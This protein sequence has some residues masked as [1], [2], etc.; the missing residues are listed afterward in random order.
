[1]TPLHLLLCAA[2]LLPLTI[3]AVKGSNKYYYTSSPWWYTFSS[4][5]YTRTSQ[6]PLTADPR[7]TLPFGLVGDRCLLVAPFLTG[8]WEE[9]RYYCHTHESQ[10]VQID[11]FEFFSILLNFLRHE[12][13]DEHSY[14]LGARDIEEEGEFRWSIGGGLVPM[15]SPF[16]AIKYASSTTYS[17]EPQ[18][19]TTSNCLRMDK[20]RYLYFDDDDCENEN[21]IM[22]EKK[23]KV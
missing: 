7:C 15:S 19:T 3:T 20:V 10:I 11:T 9:A 8:T 6:P 23:L 13:L 14:W 4:Y 5:P 18:G 1:M 22:C 12:G 2:A 16:W 17:I 21:S